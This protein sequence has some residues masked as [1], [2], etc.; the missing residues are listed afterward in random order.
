MTVWLFKNL[1]YGYLWMQFFKYAKHIAISITEVEVSSCKL[2]WMHT[3]L[4]AKPTATQL[5][6]TWVMP[7]TNKKRLSCSRPSWETKGSRPWKKVYT[8]AYFAAP[9]LHSYINQ[10]L[11]LI[12][13]PQWWVTGNLISLDGSSV[14]FKNTDFLS[15][16]CSLISKSSWEHRKNLLLKR[17]ESKQICEI[18]FAHCPNNK[19]ISPSS[20]SSDKNNITYEMPLQNPI[21]YNLTSPKNQYNKNCIMV[22][23][24]SQELSISGN[25][26]IK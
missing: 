1:S 13:L 22:Y 6:R 7:R 17:E 25:F 16:I 23:A 5:Y 2:A 14:S 19:E 26:W 21:E 3:L 12:T 24:H 4:I 15:V 18:T 8:N 9:I 11:Q 10:F 20:I